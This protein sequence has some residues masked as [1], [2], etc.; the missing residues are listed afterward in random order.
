MKTRCLIVDDEPLAIKVIQNHLEKVPDVDIVATCR[1]ALEALAVVRE[2]AV[3]LI[4]LDIEM[5]E[6]T[7]LGFIQALEHA[8]QVILITAHRDY[9]PEGFE[10]DVVD[11]LLKPVSL[12]RL[13]RALD[14]Y[15]RRCKVNAATDADASDSTP[16]YLAVRSNRRTVTIRLDDIR[17]IESLGDYV[18]I[19]T[20]DQTVI[21]KERISHLADKL[22][23]HG[24][25]RIHR[26]FLVPAARI[27]AY[28]AKEVR[29]DG[30]ALPVSRSYRQ[31]VRDR[32]RELQI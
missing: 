4:F 8:P 28:T 32:L 19:H 31:I 24:F 5:P 25:L 3:D 1:G 18:K 16:P 17:Y 12:P 9:A 2:E 27:T 26:S 22:S 30:K 11:Y 23:T 15:R 13:L 6:L 7:G 21:S 20:A 29:I 14:K 10:L